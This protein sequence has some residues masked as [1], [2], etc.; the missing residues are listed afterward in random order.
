MARF[1]Q[2]LL[3][4]ECTNFMEKSIG[5]QM[6]LIALFIDTPM[7]NIKFLAMHKVQMHAGATSKILYGFASV[8][9]IIL[10][11]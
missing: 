3:Y 9:A 10:S 5:L 1:T 11:L 4:I 6:A 7:C 2:G 8:C